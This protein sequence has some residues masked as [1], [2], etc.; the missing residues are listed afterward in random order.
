MNNYSDN[1]L[2]VE[3]AFS[4]S[5]CQIRY[6][7]VKANLHL[8]NNKL[9]NYLNSTSRKLTSL[10]L[11]WQMLIPDFIN[12]T[13][14]FYYC[15]K[16][17]KL[18]QLLPKLCNPNFINSI[19]FYYFLTLVMYTKKQSDRLCLIMIKRAYIKY[20]LLSIQPCSVMLTNEVFIIF[21]CLEILHIL[22]A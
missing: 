15:L 7:F 13:I 20:Y 1:M 9:L 6:E 19:L 10:N 2:V 18:W 12:S 11:L 17:L 5:V 22:S 21:D 4:K 16:N 3:V 8:P 14:L